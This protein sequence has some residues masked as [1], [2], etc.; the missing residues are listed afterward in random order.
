[1]GVGSIW[2]LRLEVGD[3][4]KRRGL[5]FGVNLLCSAAHQSFCMFEDKLPM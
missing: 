2:S 3:A 4:Q 1:M 5:N